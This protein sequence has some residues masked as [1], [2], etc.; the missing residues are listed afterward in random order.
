M[1]QQQVPAA[2]QKSSHN[3]H[4]SR[5]QRPSRSHHTTPTTADSCAPTE[6]ITQHPKQQ[7]PVAQQKSSHNTQNSRFQGPSRSH[8]TTPTTAAQQKSSHNTHNSR[9]LCPNRNHHTTPITAG[10]CAPTEVFTSSPW[11]YSAGNNDAK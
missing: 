4:N 8:D 5:F 1:T 2:Q 7:V 9:F 6:V 10:S 11:E 3:T